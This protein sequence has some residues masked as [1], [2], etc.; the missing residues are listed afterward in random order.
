MSQNEFDLGLPPVPAKPK[1][2]PKPVETTKF[3]TYNAADRRFCDICLD[4][5]E[6]I[7]GVPKHAIPR[8][9]HVEESPTGRT[10]LCTKHKAER[11]V[12]VDSTSATG[13]QIKRKERRK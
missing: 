7:G 10:W 2:E 12:A 1:P 5:T 13:R 4:T 6:R 3:T 8:A 11:S 9:T